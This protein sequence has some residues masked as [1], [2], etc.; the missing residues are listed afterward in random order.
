M[1]DA[2]KKYHMRLKHPEATTRIE[3]DVLDDKILLESYVEC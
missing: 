3:F 1:L 2:D